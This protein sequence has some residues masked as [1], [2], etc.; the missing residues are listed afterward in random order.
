MT[1]YH[2]EYKQALRRGDSEEANKIYR[3]HLREDGS[4]EP[5]QEEETSEPGEEVEEQSD[6]EEEHEDDL[7]NPS[8]MTVDNAKDYADN[9]EDV[10]GF[11]EFEREGKDRKTLVEYLESKIE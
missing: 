6:S 5:G 2:Y 8:S 3:E 10:E 7:E 11:L 9:I 1:D 4:E